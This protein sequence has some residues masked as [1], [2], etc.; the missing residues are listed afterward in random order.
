MANYLRM[1]NVKNNQGPTP[2]SPM[3]VLSVGPTLLLEM[4]TIICQE[5]CIKFLGIFHRQDTKRHSRLPRSHVAKP[6]KYQIGRMASV[7]LAGVS[8]H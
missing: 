6:A 8:P 4:R 7:T 5:G 2:G 3:P 1:P